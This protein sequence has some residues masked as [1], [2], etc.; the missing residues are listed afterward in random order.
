MGQGT[1]EAGAQHPEDRAEHR[2]LSFHKDSYQSQ[3]TLAQ[4]AGCWAQIII[5][6]IAHKNSDAP[7][8][9]KK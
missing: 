6:I 5:T 9:S 1:G 7:L 8:L 3:Q 4:C 2:P